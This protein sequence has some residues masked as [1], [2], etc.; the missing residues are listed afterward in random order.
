MVSPY[1]EFYRDTFLSG[2]QLICASC[3]LA[4]DAPFFSPRC[5]KVMHTMALFQLPNLEHVLACSYP[6]IQELQGSLLFC[7]E[8]E[9]F[10]PQYH[11]FLLLSPGY[12]VLRQKSKL[13]VTLSMQV[14]SLRHYGFKFTVDQPEFRLKYESKRASSLNHTVK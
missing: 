4:S 2:W 6:A 3:G 7:G 9:S 11:T 13:L 10:S 8:Q 5:F 14:Q 12:C 1:N